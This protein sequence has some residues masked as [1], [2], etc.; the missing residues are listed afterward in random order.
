MKLIIL[1]AW[2][3]TRLKP[4]TNT[5]PKPLIKIFWKTIIEHNLDN[6]LSINKDLFDEIIF[7]VKYKKEKFIDYFEDNYN[8]I[9]INYITQW[10]KKW[11]AWALM[12]LDLQDDVLII[13]WDSIFEKKDLEKIINYP[14][15]W[16]LVTQTDNPEKY[17]IYKTDEFFNAKE[18]VEKPQEFIWNLANLWVYKFSW[19]IFELIKQVKKSDRWE[20]ELPDAINNFIK[21][22]KFH[23]LPISGKFIDISYPWDILQANSYFLN[24][25]EESKINWIIEENVF[26]K[27]KII[28]EKWAIIKSWTYI[29]WNC[30]IWKNSVLGPNLYLRWQTV[31]WKNCKIWANN[32]IKNSSI[33]DNISIAH[34]SYIWDSIIWNNVN[35]WWWFVSANLRHDQKN[36][37]VLINWR[38]IDTWLRKLWVIIWD[39]VKTWIKSYSM[40]GRIIENDTFVMPWEMIK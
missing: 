2:K 34:L 25:L 33:W 28:L 19:K 1:A 10:E 20:Y 27:W 35:I 5:I 13:N 21:L 15:Y 24:K 17:W 26:I 29:E 18:I 38:L 16:A 12:W 39:N 9:K 6:I 14:W 22:E 31:I 11:T 37:K 23:L 8:W 3:G 7:I 4:I 30:Y 36:I 32:E 40:P